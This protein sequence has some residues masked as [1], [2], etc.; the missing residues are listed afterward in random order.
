MSRWLRRIKGLL[1]PQKGQPLPPK[2][3]P[4]KHGKPTRHV[5]MLCCGLGL[6]LCGV[7]LWWMQTDNG[8]HGLAEAGYTDTL[9]DLVEAIQ[10]TE[11]ESADT[12]EHASDER[13]IGDVARDSLSEPSS[14]SR[15]ENASMAVSGPQL[16]VPTDADVSGLQ[17]IG[18]N[19]VS[20]RPG[21][22]LDAG[23]PDIDGV[24]LSEYA[25][26][27]SDSPSLLSARSPSQIPGRADNGRRLAETPAWLLGL[28]ESLDDMPP[29]DVTEPSLLGGPELMLGQGR[30][31]DGGDDAGA[32][33]E[34]SQNRR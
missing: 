21:R 30:A 23:S 24:R 15:L 18:P 17:P 22:A 20:G 33:L 13:S 16:R 10:I 4:R 3:L 11:L 32:A 7:S 34:T 19:L 14:T 1:L 28:I 2:C 12:A 5:G 31:A 29:T 8:D 6:V 9:D 25:T 26:H 27:T